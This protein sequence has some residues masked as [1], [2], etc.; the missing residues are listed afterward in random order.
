MRE[1]Y[2]EARIHF[3][4]ARIPAGEALAQAKAAG[5]LAARRADSFILAARP[6]RI[7][8]IS[9]TQTCEG[10]RL[11]LRALVKTEEAQGGES[12]ALTAVTVTALNLM[13]MAQTGQ[14]E[15]VRLLTN[16]AVPAK[17]VAEKLPI[18]TRLAQARAKAQAARPSTLMGEVAAVRQEAPTAR[19]EAFRNFMSAHGLRASHW[20]KEA[21]ISPNL[22]YAFLTGRV[23]QISASDAEKLARVA[24]VRAEDMFAP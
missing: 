1:L 23:G 24:K 6:C 12:A 19:R 15:Q 14:L 8:D 2:A 9:I 4:D 10:D 20:A 11:I 21:G 13:A 17:P 16:V 5:I 7:E 18:A 22:I 3:Q